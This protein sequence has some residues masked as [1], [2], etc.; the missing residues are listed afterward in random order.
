MHHLVSTTL[1]SH[2]P[3]F[4]LSEA[5]S[6]HLT[7]TMGNGD[8]ILIRGEREG[9][10]SEVC[11]SMHRGIQW[12]MFL[13]RMYEEEYVFLFKCKAFGIVHCILFCAFGL[14]F[15]WIFYEVLGLLNFKVVGCTIIIS[16]NP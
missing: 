10:D 16:P 2:V 4:L 15:S 8:V 7:P 14:S 3:F 1:L 6:K 11:D 9:C 5:K 13:A 12:I